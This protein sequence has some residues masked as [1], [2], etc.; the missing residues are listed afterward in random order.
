MLQVSADR[1]RPR[2]LLLLSR[3]GEPLEECV[4]IAVSSSRLTLEM[5]DF[6]IDF[7]PWTQADGRMGPWPA[8]ARRWTSFEV[9]RVATI[10]ANPAA[11]SDGD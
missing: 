5:G 1:L 4:V 7:R 10:G 3:E 8:R 11:A 6:E 2:D 9:R